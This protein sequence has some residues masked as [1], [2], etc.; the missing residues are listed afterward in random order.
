MP[1]FDVAQIEAKIKPLFNDYAYQY[2]DEVAALARANMVYATL[3]DKRTKNTGDKL[4][5][6]SGALF[7]SLGR[8]DDNNIF[9]LTPTPS[10]FTVTYGSKLPY[11][12]IHEYGGN[13]GRNLAVAIP[14]RP[15]L[16][17]ALEQF[18]KTTKQ[19]FALKVKREISLEIMKW[20]EKQKR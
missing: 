14:K 10:G 4:R 17:P 6:I 9:K 16:N 7:K 13:A 2:A 19:Q 3:A 18:N 8:N 12:A 20:L 15:Y 1:L 5:R 11:A